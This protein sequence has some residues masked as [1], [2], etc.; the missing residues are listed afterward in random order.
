[1]SKRFF[2]LAVVLIALV[3][4]SEENEATSISPRKPLGA[5]CRVP[6]ECEPGLGC[7]DRV[8]VK[9]PRQDGE[10][11]SM[12]ARCA[13]GLVCNQS[14]ITDRKSHDDANYEPSESYGDR[15]RAPDDLAAERERKLLEKS[16]LS[17]EE[18]AKKLDAVAEAPKPASG[19]GLRVRVV[20]TEA[21]I[22]TARG[23]VFASCRGSERLVS[24]SCGWAQGSPG[25]RGHID[26]VDSGVAG[27]S[28]TDTVGARWVCVGG[29]GDRVVAKALCQA[30]P[31][32]GTP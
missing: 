15:C 31:G 13:E 14:A 25:V 5:I 10:S 17:E 4:C 27:H 24:G 30:L 16:G 2:Y 29:K 12:W 7:A 18:I 6:A 32:Q 22:G 1:M 21:T 26:D 23:T 8:C 11:C 19:P 20:R 9:V 3:G 28:D